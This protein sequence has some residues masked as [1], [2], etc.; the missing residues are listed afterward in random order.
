M[1]SRQASRTFRYKSTVKILPP[2]LSPEKAKVA[3]FYAARSRIIPPL[4]WKTF[5]PP[6]SQMQDAMY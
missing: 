4:P 3:D 2:S 6:F 5:A 1:P